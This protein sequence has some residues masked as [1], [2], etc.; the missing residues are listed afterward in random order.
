MTFRIPLK[1]KLALMAALA[2][3][4]AT[5]VTTAPAGAIIA[6]VQCGTVKAKGKKWKITADQVRCATAKKW[7][8]TYIRTFRA[9]R[10]YTCKRGSAG[11]SIYRVCVATRYNPD[12]TFFIRRG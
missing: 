10:Y 2:A 11:S 1:I 12:R 3:L 9:P 5:A 6:P 4:A 7:S 8:V